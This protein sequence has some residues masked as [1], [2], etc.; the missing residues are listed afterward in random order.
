MNFKNFNEPPLDEPHHIEENIREA[1]KEIYYWQYSNTNS[2]MNNLI[3]LFH[4]AD[5]NNK[6]R[7]AKGF[8]WVRMAYELWE[9]ADTQDE[10]FKKWLP[11]IWSKHE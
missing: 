9:G 10:F 1:A 11:E 6:H 4:K 5:F 3:S 8:P 7:L 2:F